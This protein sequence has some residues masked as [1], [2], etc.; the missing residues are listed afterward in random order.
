MGVA[1]RHVTFYLH[2]MLLPFFATFCDRDVTISMPYFR[3][4]AKFCDNMDVTNAFFLSSQMFAFRQ[5]CCVFSPQ[6]MS[7]DEMKSNVDQ[8]TQLTKRMEEA[9][10]ELESI[11]D[12]ERLL[13]WEESS[14]PELNA[15]FQAKEPYEKL[16]TTALHFHNS[17]ETWM[18]GKSWGRS[19]HCTRYT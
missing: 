7:M 5:V 18:N 13:E 11:N 10:T 12:E 1:F 19:W 17:F 16:W 8:L 9:R 4:L 3:L 2:P 6:I 15:T 14:F